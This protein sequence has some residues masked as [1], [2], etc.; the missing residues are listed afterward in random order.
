MERFS[1]FEGNTGPYILYTIVR[2]KSI[3]SKYQE[4]VG[5]LPAQGIILPPENQI[6]K[7]L[8]LQVSRF[9]DNL[10]LAYRDTQ[11]NVVCAYIYELSGAVNRFY[12]ETR[13]LAETDAE[14]QKGYIAL[15]SLVKDILETCI[16]LLGFEAPE[17]M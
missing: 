9:A 8:M 4:Q 12:H 2:I 16:D 3:L 14:K 10:A 7:D 15:I 5:A 17:K 13:I 6:E 11:P 1:A